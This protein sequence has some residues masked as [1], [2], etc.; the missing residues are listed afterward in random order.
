MIYYLM[1]HSVSR[2][3]DFLGQ[4]SNESHSHTVTQSHRASQSEEMAT[5]GLAAVKQVLIYAKKTY[6][7]QEEEELIKKIEESAKKYSR[8]LR[9]ST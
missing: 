1:I 9:N 8:T 6:T 5:L 7:L 4:R 3:T 2:Q